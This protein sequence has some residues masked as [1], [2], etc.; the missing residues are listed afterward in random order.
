MATKVTKILVCLFL[1]VGVYAHTAQAQITF[2]TGKIGVRLSNAGSIR[3]MAPTSSDNQQLSR[4]NI[5]AAR[6]EEAVNDYNEDQDLVIDAYQVAS[7]TVADIEAVAVYDNSYSGLPPDVMFRVHVFAWNNESYLIAKYT[8]INREAQADTLYLG[9]VNVPRIAGNYGG[10]TDVFNADHGLAYCFRE[11]EAPHGGYRFLSQEPFSYHALDWMDYSPADPNSDAATD[12]TRFHMTADP[13]F[14]STIVAGG[15]GSIY[16]LN[17]GAFII[18]PGDSV[19]FTCAIV[20]AD[21]ETDLFAASDAAKDKYESLNLSVQKT[22]NSVVPESFILEQNYPNPFNPTTSIR[23]ALNKNSEVQ[24]AVYNV[25][26]HL[27]QT[28]VSGSYSAGS[29]QATWDGMDSFG[30]NVS[31]GVYIYRLTTNNTTFSKKMLLVR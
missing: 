30:R 18:A 16:S 15:D 23:F 2:D 5:I 14:D 4:V 1:I 17:A 28:I 9:L 22:A 29:Y 31:S 20:Y 26:G 7:P 10:E 11:G 24:L 21:S 3:I 25:Q 19:K 8:V 27:V 12:A 6:S 13:G